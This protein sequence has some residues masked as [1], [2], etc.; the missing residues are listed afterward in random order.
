VSRVCPLS[1]LS[2]PS[3]SPDLKTSYHSDKSQSPFSFFP[4]DPPPNFNRIALLTSV[5]IL[6]LEYIILLCFSHRPLARPRYHPWVT[7][8]CSQQTSYPT[9]SLHGLMG[10]ILDHIAQPLRRS[11]LYKIT[12]TNSVQSPLFPL[13]TSQP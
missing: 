3:G 7:R 8:L 10:M 9:C 13:S 11:L 6:C 4:P 1:D 5:V 12:S 2:Y